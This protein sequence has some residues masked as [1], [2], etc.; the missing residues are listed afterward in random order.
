VSFERQPIRV[1]AKPRRPFAL[2]ALVKTLVPLGVRRWLRGSQFHLAHSTLPMRRVRDFGELR[3]TSPIGKDFG[4]LR[5][6]PV[7]RYY[8]ESF[9]QAHSRHVR[10]AVLEV[11]SDTYTR[12]FGGADVIRSDVL[13]VTANDSIATVIADLGCPDSL[14][15]AQ[16]DCIFCTQ[17]L[18][19]IYNLKAAAA[20]LYSAL[21]P[22]GVLL[23][24]VPGVAHKLASDE[25]SGDY[26]RFTPQSIERLFAEQF[27]PN[28]IHI[29]THGNVLAA[30]AFL[31]GLAVEELSVEEL[32][33]HD[34]EYPVTI[35]LCAVKP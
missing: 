7:D 3:S 16:Y 28:S 34:P 6:T 20:N 12:R 30:I 9:L 31:H 18:L 10:G 2:R 11:Q 21:R 5:G 14:P 19:L 26:W 29:S 8:I 22:G 1:E 35:G 27:P 4:R 32:D 25:P 17:T 33:Q 13:D 15:K 23:L 24:T